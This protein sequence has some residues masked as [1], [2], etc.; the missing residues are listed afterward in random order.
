MGWLVNCRPRGSGR[1]FGIDG[2]EWIVLLFIGLVV[3]GPQRLPEYTH[4]LMQGVRK[5]RKFVEESRASVES[6]MGVAVDE[7]RKYDPRQYD[8]RRIVREAWGDTNPIQELVDDTKN[9][10]GDTKKTLTATGAAAGAAGIGVGAT[11][12]ASASEEPAPRN[13]PFDP[14][15]T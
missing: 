9:L 5:L 10:V 3:I 8:P 13:A 2:W 6:E 7:L 15:A 14:E 11:E 1:V 12:P 4:N